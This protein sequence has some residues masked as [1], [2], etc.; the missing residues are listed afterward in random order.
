MADNEKDANAE[1]EPEGVNVG[2]QRIRLNVVVNGTDVHVV[3]NLDRPLASLIPRSLFK[4][5]VADNTDPDRWIFKD[6]DG[7]VLDKTKNIGTFG[8]V[9]KATLYLSLDAGVA[10]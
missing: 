6:K 3:G 2:P 8:F 10:G 4:A 1:F 5:G 7:N 9:P